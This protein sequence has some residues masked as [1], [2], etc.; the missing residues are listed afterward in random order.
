M[1]PDFRMCRLDCSLRAFLDCMLL[2]QQL[3]HTLLI[4]RQLHRLLVQLHSTA[5]QQLLRLLLH[6]QQHCAILLRYHQ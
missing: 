1:P 2:L 3:L 5:Q 6:Q 4:H